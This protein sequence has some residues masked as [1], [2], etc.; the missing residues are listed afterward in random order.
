M[1]QDSAIIRGH[2][3]V[4]EKMARDINILRIINA[5]YKKIIEE[6]DKEIRK[7]RGDTDADEI[8]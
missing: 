6:M 8:R 1:N 3:A 7:L 5:E 2:Y 4:R